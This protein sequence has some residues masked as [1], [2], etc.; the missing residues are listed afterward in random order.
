MRLRIL[1]LAKH[2]NVIRPICT[3]LLSENHTP[4]HRML[5]GTAVMTAGVTVAKVFGHSDL[6]LIA[7]IGDAVG[8]GIHALGMTPFIEHL[9]HQF[10]GEHEE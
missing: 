7:Y 5:V 1:T 8:Y 3:H 4:H 6:M 2:A 9:L 10:V